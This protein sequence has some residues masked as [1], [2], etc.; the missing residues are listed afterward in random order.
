MLAT[1]VAYLRACEAPGCGRARRFGKIALALAADADLFLDHRQAARRAPA[2]RARRR[3]LRRRRARPAR[4]TSPPP[5]R[6]A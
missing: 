3:G 5:R 6:S 2:G 1:L 4:C